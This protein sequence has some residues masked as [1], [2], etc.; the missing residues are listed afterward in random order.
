MNY[1][2]APD[3]YNLFIKDLKKFKKNVYYFIIFNDIP[4]YPGYLQGGS[5]ISGTL[6]KVKL[7]PKKKN[8]LIN[9]FS[10]NH[11]SCLLKHK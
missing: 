7:L 9:S 3:L 5:D 4:Y 2:P 11:L 6:S 8:F 10:K 1:C